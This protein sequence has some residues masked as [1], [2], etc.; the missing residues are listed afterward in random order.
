MNKE[1]ATASI[2]QYSEMCLGY[3][4]L[5]VMLAP[6]YFAAQLAIYYSFITVLL[7]SENTLRQLLP[8]TKY[9]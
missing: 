6:S 9:A 8:F 1:N 2:T 3:P 5:T 7:P 4:S